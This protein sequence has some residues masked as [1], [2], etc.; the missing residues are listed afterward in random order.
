M[1]LEQL[2]NPLIVEWTMNVKGNLDD[3]WDFISNTNRLN[4]AIGSDK[5]EYTQ[6]PLPQGGTELHG[7]VGSTE[8]L[9]LPYEWIENKFA[10]MSRIYLNGVIKKLN[11]IISAQQKG[12]S[13][14]VTFRFEF[15]LKSFIMKFLVKKVMEKQTI[16]RFQKVFSQIEK[17]LANKKINPLT[18]YGFKPITENKEK[19]DSISKSIDEI[20]ADSN[21]KKKIINYIAES[22]DPELLKMKP[23]VVADKIDENRKKVLEFFLRATKSG[24]FNMNW[25]ILCPSCKGAKASSNHLNELANSVHCPSCN[26][27]YGPDFDKSV[28]LT[29]TPNE[30]L[31]TVV[32]GVYCFGGPGGT[33]HLRAQLRVKAKETL[34][35]NF[36]FKKGTYR[37]FSLQQKEVLTIEVTNDPSEITEVHYPKEDK[38]II[39]SGTRKIVFTNP[40]EYEILIKLER[41]NWL[42][43]VVTAYEVT[44]MQEFRDLFSSEVLRTGQEISIQSI[45][46]IF[47]DLKGSTKFYNDNG[48][49]IAYKM[50]SD[51][52]QVLI[53]NA[54]KFDG[55]IVKTIGDAVMGVFINPLQAVQYCIEIQ[56]EI[57]KLNERLKGENLILKVGAHIGPALA[58]TMNDKLDYFGATI[59][60]AARTEGQCKGG[61]VVITKKLFEYPT[62]S[63]FLKESGY[64]LEEFETSIKGFSESMEMIRILV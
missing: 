26:I 62:V 41:T 24:L 56:K 52:F 35:E 4:Q 40:N 60:L 19:F 42:D 21:L 23:Y 1:I 13:F 47:T 2:N 55:A 53:S 59:N 44:A 25:D 27:D 57:K 7:K 43:A 10:S 64:K 45:A 9:E 46:I 49:A 18:S 58:V 28:E 11:F 36:Y 63:A 22:P 12:E 34:S 30:I 17:Y 6:I 51:H 14:D 8:Y 5:V 50:V 16:P 48:D 32:G 15:E 29:F 39:Q 38:I 20:N 37:I 31:R 33:P 3:G 61:D 54:S